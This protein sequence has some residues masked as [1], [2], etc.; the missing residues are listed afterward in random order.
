MLLRVH[1]LWL[2]CFK[3]GHFF[4]TTVHRCR[5]FHRPHHLLPCLEKGVHKQQPANN[6]PNVIITHVVTSLLKQ[7][8]FSWLVGSNLGLPVVWLPKPENCMTQRPQYPSSQ[9][10]SSMWEKWATTHSWSCSLYYEI[11]CVNSP[12]LLFRFEYTKL[13]LGCIDTDCHLHACEQLHA[14]KYDNASSVH[15]APAITNKASEF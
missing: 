6:P 8:P 11:F 4:Q 1:S 15:K 12:G 5:R 9:K 13:Q 7:I 3:T 10:L 14:V 2:N